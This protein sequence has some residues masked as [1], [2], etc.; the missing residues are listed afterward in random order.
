VIMRSSV[1]MRSLLP[2][3]LRLTLRYL[4]LH[5]APSADQCGVHQLPQNDQEERGHSSKV[6]SNQSP[7]RESGHWRPEQMAAGLLHGRLE[8]DLADIDIR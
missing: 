2:D 4:A 3:R 1:R 6:S 8:P 7:R 5:L